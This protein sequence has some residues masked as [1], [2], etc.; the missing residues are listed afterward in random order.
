MCKQL[1]DFPR[2][3]K[4]ILQANLDEW[5]LPYLAGVNSIAALKKVNVFELLQQSLSWQ[6]QQ[7]LN[8]Q[9]P[10]EYKAPSNKTVA[11]VYDEQQGPTV[12]V[13]L[14]EMFGEVNSPKIGGGKVP[15]R[16]ELLSPARRPIQTT[17]D[18][19]NFWQTS[20]FAVAKDMRGRY[21]RHR[22]PDEPLLE[23]AGKSIKSKKGA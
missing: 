5:L 16:F 9:A 1:D 19:A 3:S 12:S 13:Q 11:I 21:P 6:D 23:K 22:W 10:I 7:T 15:I 18:L 2:V 4:S 8:S 20:Y 14:Q 17:S